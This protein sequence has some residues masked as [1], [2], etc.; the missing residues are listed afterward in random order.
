MLRARDM[1]SRLKGANVLVALA[2]VCVLNVP[3]TGTGLSHVFTVLEEARTAGLIVCYTVTQA[4]LEQVFLRI[5]DAQ[6]E[7][8]REES[9]VSETRERLSAGGGGRCI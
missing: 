1:C 7:V 3:T 8:E 5:A 4:S 2:G 9:D 6:G